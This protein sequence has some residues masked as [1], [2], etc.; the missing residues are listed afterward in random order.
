MRSGHNMQQHMCLFQLPWCCPLGAGGETQQA[1]YRSLLE[2]STV[3]Y[4]HQ[5]QLLLLLLFLFLNPSKCRGYFRPTHIQFFNRTDKAI[6]G[7]QLIGRFHVRSITPFQA[8]EL[9]I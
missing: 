8:A 4:W 5:P 9:V 2:K 7:K 6:A 1:E 3:K